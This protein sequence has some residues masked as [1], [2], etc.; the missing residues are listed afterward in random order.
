MRELLNKGGKG[1]FEKWRMGLNFKTPGDR[2]TAKSLKK[3][4]IYFAVHT[5]NRIFNA[6]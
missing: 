5:K 2:K 4:K 1:R 3:I 6:L